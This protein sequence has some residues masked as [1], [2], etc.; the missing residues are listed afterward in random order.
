MQNWRHEPVSPFAILYL[1]VSPRKKLYIWSGGGGG[2]GVLVI[3]QYGRC[4]TAPHMCDRGNNCT[5]PCQN[6]FVLE[7]LGKEGAIP[8]LIKPIKDTSILYIAL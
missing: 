7:T 1:C 8:I 5:H 3:L 6:I 4:E 2:G